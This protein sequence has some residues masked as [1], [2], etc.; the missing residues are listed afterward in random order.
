MVVY[1]RKPVSE[2]T[3][4]HLD[5][6][7]GHVVFPEDNGSLIFRSWVTAMNYM[8]R[9]NAVYELL[10]NV[11]NYYKVTEA[12][13]L[14]LNHSQSLCLSG[15]SHKITIDSVHKQVTCKRCI[16]VQNEGNNPNMS[17]L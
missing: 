17:I 3:V 14:P 11:P 2:Y 5:P 1:G 10:T 15:N 12:F 9:V 6:A 13:H 7:K 4:C 8:D 16:E